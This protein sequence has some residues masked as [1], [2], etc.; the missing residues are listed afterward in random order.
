MHEELWKIGFDCCS[1]LDYGVNDCFDFTG[2]PGAGIAVAVAA[3]GGDFDSRRERNV[4]RLSGVRVFVPHDQY[5]C[6]LAYP[7]RPCKLDY[8]DTSWLARP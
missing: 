6:K 2:E 5:Q 8:A 4:I 7:V 3:C 1:E